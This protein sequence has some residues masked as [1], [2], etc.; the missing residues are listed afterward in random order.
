MSDKQVSS[1]IIDPVFGSLTKIVNAPEST[2]Q[3]AELELNWYAT[4]STLVRLASS[5]LDAEYDEFSSYTF[6]QSLVENPDPIDLSGTRIQNT[7]E[8][9]H[10]LMV[11]HEI[12]L[13]RTYYA[14]VG[15]DWAYSDE[16]NSLVGDNP[17]FTVDS[18]NVLNLRGGFVAED[19][20]WQVTAWV[21]N[22]TDE[23]YFTAVSPSNDA[24]VHIL[25]RER[26]FG[27]SLQYNW[28]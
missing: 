15:G 14:F 19:N 6:G 5:Y 23:E 27:L 22:L 26:T 24:N 11:H 20:S 8:W 28:E 13:N 7:P 16:F 25:G 4:E 2:V 18:Y 9:Q 21:K 12:N 3:G 1:F 10:N 17:V